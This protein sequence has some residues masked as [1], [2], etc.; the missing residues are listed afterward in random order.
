MLCMIVLQGQKVLS[1]GKSV[2]LM[3]IDRRS[4]ARFLYLGLLDKE[5]QLVGRLTYNPQ[6]EN[7]HF[8]SLIYNTFVLSV[9]NVLKNCAPGP[10]MH[11]YKFP[12]TS[13]CSL[14]CEESCAFQISSNCTFYLHHSRKIT[15]TEQNIVRR[16]CETGPYFGSLNCIPAYS[17]RGQ[18]CNS[19]MVTKCR[20]NEPRTKSPQ[21]EIVVSWSFLILR[22]CAIIVGFIH[23]STMMLP[24]KAL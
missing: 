14:S 11:K 1:H 12:Q 17:D 15:M 9:A 22:H 6:L 16:S 7:R 10:K 2:V 8:C 4:S 19:P 21:I 24:L 3:S 20:D 13:N 5:L 18:T 23:S